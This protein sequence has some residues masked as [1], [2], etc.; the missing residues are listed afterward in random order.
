MTNNYFQ[1]TGRPNVQTNAKKQTVL[2][3]YYQQYGLDI[4]IYHCEVLLSTKDIRILH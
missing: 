2:L 4:W 1:T 3:T